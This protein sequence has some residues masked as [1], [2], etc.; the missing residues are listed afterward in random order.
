MA[1]GQAQVSADNLFAEQLPGWLV[2][3]GHK[4]GINDQRWLFDRFEDGER[5]DVFSKHGAVPKRPEEIALGGRPAKP[6]LGSKRPDGEDEEDRVAPELQRRAIGPG[7]EI[8]IYAF[9]DMAERGGKL[10]P[11]D[12][13]RP[14]ALG[15]KRDGDETCQYAE[16]DD[17]EPFFD[18]AVPVGKRGNHQHRCERSAEAGCGNDPLVT[19]TLEPGIDAHCQK[20]RAKNERSK[21]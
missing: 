16:V 10:Q 17:H 12:P 14:E 4:P 5:E 2:G 1:N 9:Q 3:R 15:A 21:H 20:Q 6:S 7:K 19:A 18:T 13:E 11:R 8:R